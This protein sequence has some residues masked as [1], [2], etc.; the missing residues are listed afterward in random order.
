MLK[1]VPKERIQL[2]R[3]WSYANVL[4]TTLTDN[5]SKNFLRWYARPNC[6][7]YIILD[8]VVAQ[9]IKKSKI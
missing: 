5:K 1:M 2:T 6:L 8:L 4:H 9:N 7:M 3:K